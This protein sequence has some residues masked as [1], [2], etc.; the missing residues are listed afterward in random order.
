MGERLL[1]GGAGVGR[2][3]VSVDLADVGGPGRGLGWLWHRGWLGW[4][5][6]SRYWWWGQTHAQGGQG[7][8]RACGQVGHLL[9]A[10][11]GFVGLAVGRLR[12]AGR[13]AFRHFVSG[14]G[15]SAH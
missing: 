6:G 5:W 1:E 2:L 10:V 4:G 9:D 13:P 15:I 7:E 11:K 3:Q 12:W 8:G 14:T